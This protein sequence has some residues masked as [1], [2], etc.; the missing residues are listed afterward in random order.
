MKSTL[1][2]LRARV[3]KTLVDTRYHI[4]RLYQEPD[5]TESIHTPEI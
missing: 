3:L 5:G 4:G 2:I 1:Q